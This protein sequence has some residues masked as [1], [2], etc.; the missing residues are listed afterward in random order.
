[1]AQCKR[2]KGEETREPPNILINT[3]EAKYKYKKKVI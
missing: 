2:Q 1:M 3:E